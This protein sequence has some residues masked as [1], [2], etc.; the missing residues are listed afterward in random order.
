L[1]TSSSLKDFL[2][3]VPGI[4]AVAEKD[5]T[6]TRKIHGLLGLAK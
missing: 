4:W 3:T 2:A 6:V 5:W 1:D